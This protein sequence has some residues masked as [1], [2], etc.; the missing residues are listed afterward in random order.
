[1]PSPNGGHLD[2]K[3]SNKILD[4]E[5]VKR[6]PQASTGEFVMLSIS[7]T[8]EGMSSEIQENALEPFFTTKDAENGTGL[9]LVW[10]KVL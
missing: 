1:M 6:N 7:D 5:Y 10:S 2:I 9:G 4:Q 8:G 3:T